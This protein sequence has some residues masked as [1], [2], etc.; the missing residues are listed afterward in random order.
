MKNRTQSG[1]FG[2]IAALLVVTVTIVLM[3]GLIEKVIENKKSPGSLNYTDSG[4]SKIYYNDSWYT[5]NKSIKTL[6]VL[7]IDRMSEKE[8][9]PS[10]ADFIALV[11]MDKA[12]ESFRI[13]HINRDTMIDINQLDKHGN[14]YGSFKAQLALAHSYG[15]T[16]KIQCRNTVASVE[17]LLYGIDIDHYMSVT[18]D[19]VPIINDSIGGVTLTLD[20]DYPALGSKY[21]KNAEITLMGEDALTF[22]RWR[23]DSPDSSNLERM[24]RQRAYIAAAFEQYSTLDDDPALDTMFDISEYL[25]SDCTVNQLSDLLEDLQGYTY[26]G[27]FPVEGEAKKG[28]EYVEFYADED[29]LK[30]TVIDLFYKQEGDAR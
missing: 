5:L 17:K 12:D 19:A 22:V 3:F 11:V 26:N 29:A 23:N 10:Q 30:Q 27:T 14:K 24:E 13:L 18:M 20:A 21:V 25:V 2:L 8:S 4:D 15:G 9:A 28:S 1:G 16:D 7:G 6:L